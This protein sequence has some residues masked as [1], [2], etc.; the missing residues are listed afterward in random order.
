MPSPGPVRAAAVAGTWYPGDPGRI[1]AEVDA[2]LADVPPRT[3][4]GRLVALVS[5][6]AGLRYSGAVA[7]HG[8]AL[9]RGRSGLTLMSPETPSAGPGSSERP[10]P[11]PL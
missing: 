10:A 2:Y 3:L 4:P 1:A 9:L 5:P 6:H 11:S 7:A 8:Y